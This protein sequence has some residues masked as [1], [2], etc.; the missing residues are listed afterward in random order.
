MKGHAFNKGISNEGRIDQ[1]EPAS[2]F[3][4]LS[5]CRWLNCRLQTSTVFGSTGYPVVY[6]FLFA[7]EMH[8]CRTAGHPIVVV[9][10]VI[11][12]QLMSNCSTFP[13]AHTTIQEHP[14]LLTVRALVVAVDVL[15]MEGH[16]ATFDLNTELR[17][18]RV[19]LASVALVRW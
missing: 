11:F 2:S 10:H 14:W 12:K 8:V 18:L 1:Y 3:L 19:T 6:N 7:V 13:F 4:F 9:C 17:I 5:I 16:L 15:L